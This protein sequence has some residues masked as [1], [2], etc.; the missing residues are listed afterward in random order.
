M[1]PAAQDPL[2]TFPSRDQAKTQEDERRRATQQSKLVAPESQAARHVEDS[3]VPGKEKGAASTPKT[4]ISRG[5]SPNRPAGSGNVTRARATSGPTLRSQQTFP[6]SDRIYGRANKVTKSGPL[7]NQV[8]SNVTSYPQKSTVSSS[9]AS[10]NAI[11]TNTIIHS[12][13]HHR[14]SS[15]C[16]KDLKLTNPLWDRDEIEECYGYVCEKYLQKVRNHPS[17]QRWKNDDETRLLWI[18]S[19]TGQT[20]DFKTRDQKK[21]IAVA[22]IKELEQSLVVRDNALS[23]MYCQNSKI[24]ELKLD[25]TAAILRGLIWML[26]LTQE[27]L[28][29]RL[30]IAY[31]REGRSM[32]TDK[33]ASSYLLNILTEWLRDTNIGIVYLVV[34]AIDECYPE[35][36]EVL[37]LI[38]ECCKTLPKV[39]WVITS[40]CDD[41]YS[42]YIRYIEGKLDPYHLSFETIHLNERRGAGSKAGRRAERRQRKKKA[43]DKGTKGTNQEMEHRREESG[44]VGEGSLDIEK[45]G[46]S[47]TISEG[48]VEEF[49][50]GVAGVNK[51]EEPEVSGWEKGANAERA[52]ELKILDERILPLTKRT[53]SSPLISDLD[54]TCIQ[55]LRGYEKAKVVFSPNGQLLASWSSDGIVRLWDTQTCKC[56]SVLGGHPNSVLVVAFSPD[57][58]RVALGSSDCTI[59]L[60]DAQSGDYCSYLQGHSSSV[61]TVIFSPNGQLVASGSDDGTVRLWYTQTYKCHSVLEGHSSSVITVVFSPNSRLVASGSIDHTVRLWH[62][63]TGEYCFLLEGHLSLVTI[64]VFSPNGRLVASGSLDHAVRLWD[65]QTG[66]CRSLFKGHSGLINTIVFSPD[67]WLLASGSGDGTLQL[68]D[69]Q[70]YECRSVFKGH[71]SSVVAVM[72]TP[73]GQFI[74]SGSNN[75]NVQ[76]WDVQTGTCRSLLKGSSTLFSTVVFSPNG[77]LVASGSDDGTVQFW[78]LQTDDSTATN[79]Q[80][81]RDKDSDSSCDLSEASSI[82]STPSL[83]SDSSLASM[84]DDYAS[85]AAQ[86]LAA[87]LSE[88]PELPSMYGDAIANFGREKFQKNHDQLLKA[89]FKDLRSET[90]NGIQRAAVRGLRNRDRR[91]E[92]TLMIQAQY[93]PLSANWKQQMAILRDQKPNRKQLLDNHLREWTNPPQIDSLTSLGNDFEQ[94]D[95]LVDEG[96]SSNSSDDKND[97]RSD[98]DDKETYSYLEPLENFIKEAAAFARFKRNFRYLLQPPIDLSRALKSQDVRVVQRF[99]TRNFV[100]AATSDYAWLRELDEAKYSMREIAEL[101]IED[102]SE[103]PLIYFTP[104]VHV[105]HH[106]R[107]DYHIPGCAHQMSF[108]INAKPL[109]SSEQF[110]SRPP[111][112]TDVR[113]L[114]E[115]LCGI[116]GVVP[117]SK[118]MSTWHGSIT[119]QEQS[120]MS[121]I[122]YA[123]SSPAAQQSRNDLMV[124][125][126]NVL[127]NFCNAAAAVQSSGVCCDSFTVL[128]CIK[129]CLELRRVKFHHAWTMISHI[130]L[131]S[132]DN[133][134]EVAIQHCVKEAEYI[135]QEL[136]VPIPETTPNA[137]LHYCA[138][139]AQFLCLAFLSYVQA[140]VGSIDPLF[141]DTPQRKIVLLG[142]QRAP[143][144]FAINAK[145]F[146]LTCL[147]EMVQQL[148]FAFSSGATTWES[149]LESE[150]SQYDVRTNAEDCLDTWGPGYFIHS[151]ANPNEIHAVAIGGGFISM[152]DSRNLRFHWTRGKLPDSASP[153][154]FEPCTI[155]RISAPISI[156]EECSINEA[157][158]RESSFCA[159]EPLGTFE[160]F[161]EARERQAGFQAGQYLAGTCSQ[162]YKKIRG[163]T[164]KERALEQPDWCLI[165]FLEQSWGLQVSFCTSV[166]RRVS[167]RELVTDLFTM[168]VNPLKQDTW[169]ELIN[170]H[171][172]IQAFTQGDIFAWLRTLSQKLQDFVLAL[173][174][175]ILERLQYTGL[176]RRNTTLM[177]AWPR[178]GDIERG[179]KIPCRAETCWAQLIADAEDC[180]TFAYVTPKCLETNHVK[181]RGSQ[182]AW[183]NVSK[184]LVTEMSPS[185]PEGQPAFVAKAPI[186]DP[187]AAPVTT[188]ATATSQWELE[189]Q[190]TYYIKKLD[191][192]L[193]VK[194]ER[195]R[196]ASNDV[197]HLLVVNSNAPHKLWKRLLLMEER[198]NHRIRERQAIGDCAELVVIRAGLIRA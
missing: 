124:I 127:A 135:L 59:Q 52:K 176:D 100:S 13:P 195:P 109:Q 192:L 96:A 51:Y 57:S 159:L 8:W 108:N 128:L 38:I 156:N 92:I 33:H 15:Y 22:I 132:R 133:G 189:D 6:T 171:N 85:E 74:I 163:I 12:Y 83:E 16:I 56:L 143:G 87:L 71:S 2:S 70:T 60:W 139:A 98:Q 161:W 30:E 164:L 165:R 105:R 137:D 68:W 112:H 39:K 99:L 66:E 10:D 41:I 58:E 3:P 81:D 14:S 167:L 35:R 55:A 25:D 190:K 67:G 162:T 134:T 18:Y 40:D 44:L 136:R 110:S 11:P 9:F 149:R 86:H 147:A 120:S 36:K 154:A 198:R 34:G 37:D 180:A 54:E 4:S 150:T 123:N 122:T 194:V 121:V 155:M 111:L 146:G 186:A 142:S 166:A 26:C 114:V 65:K 178:E 31:S 61:K 185:R 101:L 118:D 53:P 187:P 130:N 117:S 73:S 157:M 64:V 5:R 79:H 140:H 69:T 183:Q 173:V 19:Y 196:P 90:L 188:T 91:H 20:M 115:E 151:K 63:Q 179:L 191:S 32:Y 106:I 80:T 17:Y 89:F 93:E 28:T 104:R 84:R 103:S 24:L 48:Y 125:I 50:K 169:Q 182:R 144:D 23:Y 97:R 45:G 153:V 77:R 160:V 29:K 7:A 49:F 1:D 168:F 94:D 119:F 131:A 141:L 184:M 193:C 43:L 76:L 170:N 113:R 62:A 116:G 27:S 152:V 148:V 47:D 75:L 181:C 88:D 175:S 72:F 197:A 129:N 172:I 102:N 21:I 174:R 177:I 158:Y 138:L 82:Q 78:D 46:A 145:L 95:G 107:T 126:S 42:N